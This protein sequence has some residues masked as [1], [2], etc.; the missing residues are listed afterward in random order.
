[1]AEKR[2]RS[3]LKTF[4]VV[5]VAIAVLI[6]IVMIATGSGEGSSSGPSRSNRENILRR[7]LHY[8]SELEDVEWVE[9]DGNDV[10]IGFTRRPADLEAVLRAAALNGNRAIDFGVHVWA[11]P[12]ADKGWRPGSGQYYAEVTARNGKIE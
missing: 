3:G 12:A 1:M 4:L 10:Y 11:A 8:L 5:T 6:V 7:E 2:K 9:F